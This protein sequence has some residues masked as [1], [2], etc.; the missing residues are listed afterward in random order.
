M[1]AQRKSLSWLIRLRSSWSTESSR[2]MK[3]ESRATGKAS[4]TCCRWLPRQIK[5]LLHH[6][7]G[8]E[9]AETS[10]NTH[11]ST[12]IRSWVQRGTKCTM[13]NL[14][15]GH[16]RTMAT[17]DLR[18][19]T[20]TTHLLTKR[21]SASIECKL[22]LTWLIKCES[23]ARLAWRL[24]RTQEML[25]CK[26]ERHET[27]PPSTRS[28]RTW[29]NTS[30]SAKSKRPIPMDETTRAT[31]KCRTHLM[32]RAASTAL[33]QA[34]PS[35]Q[36]EMAVSSEKLK[37]SQSSRPVLIWNS[38]CVITKSRR[39]SLQRTSTRAGRASMVSSPI[40]ITTTTK[41]QA[42]WSNTTRGWKALVRTA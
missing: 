24:P 31:Y 33:T 7:A 29:A 41:Q 42:K 10:H 14:W 27:V 2:S 25:E 16:K 18:S 30:V 32:D 9:P 3:T 36:H 20:W 40:S 35:T 37:W 15:K 17:T 6:K 12:M 11:L 28:G 26:I 34:P 23:C 13:M 39:I 4:L 21:L 38:L 1:S 22:T 19:E 8:A 5:A